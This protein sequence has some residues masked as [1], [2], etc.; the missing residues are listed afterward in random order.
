MQ[1]AWKSVGLGGRQEERQGPTFMGIEVV[2]Y[3]GCKRRPKVGF[4]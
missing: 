4:I 3:V 1:L 2:I